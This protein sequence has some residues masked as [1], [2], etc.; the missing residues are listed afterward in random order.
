MFKLSYRIR[1]NLQNCV[2]DFWENAVSKIY[3]IDRS[4][5][6][7]TLENESTETQSHPLRPPLCGNDDADPLKG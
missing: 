3:T 2:S 5:L 4:F 7:N 1:S 6:I